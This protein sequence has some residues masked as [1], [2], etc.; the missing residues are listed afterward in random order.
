MEEVV[1]AEDKQEK[2][3]RNKISIII[4]FAYS[5]VVFGFY[6]GWLEMGLIFVAPI[7]STMEVLD[8]EVVSSPP[9]PHPSRAHPLV[10][11]AMYSRSGDFF[12]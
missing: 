9:P 7:D 12:L 11:S 1:S 6:D 5:G 2:F 8:M 4:H 3:M 10:K